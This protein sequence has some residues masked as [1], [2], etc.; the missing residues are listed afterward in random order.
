MG[1][2]TDGSVR[3]DFAPCIANSEVKVHTDRDHVPVVVKLLVHNGHL[4]RLFVRLVQR[5]QKNGPKAVPRSV[6]L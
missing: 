4:A 1:R 5:A 6:L 2:T 3:G